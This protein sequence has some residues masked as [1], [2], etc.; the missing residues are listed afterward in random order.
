MTQSELVK[1]L[2]AGLAPLLNPDG[3]KWEA[4]DTWFIKETDNAY[5]M[6]S[7]SIYEE[8]EL[9]TN[10]KVFRVEPSVF[11]HVKEVEAIFIEN[12]HIHLRRRQQYFTL[13]GSVFVLAHPDNKEYCKRANGTLKYYAVDEEDVEPILKRLF[14]IYREFAVDYFATYGS[15]QGADLALNSLPEKWCTH[16][17][18]GPHRWM[19]GLI[20]ARLARNPEYVHL[21][22]V[23]STQIL[24]S[25]SQEQTSFAL[26]KEYLNKMLI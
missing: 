9:N 5:L 17:L 21:E 15:I 18:M 8:R 23:Y 11:I 25:D 22:T 13:G 2:H 3:F 19:K 14:Q 24:R 16:N 1:E 7:L 12:Y 4:T 6:Y 26:I 10:R 20:A